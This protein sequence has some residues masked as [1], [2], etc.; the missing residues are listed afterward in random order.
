MKGYYLYSMDAEEAYVCVVTDRTIRPLREYDEQMC[1]DVAISYAY[2]D[3]KTLAMP[4]RDEL[5]ARGVSA[6]LL[7]VDTDPAEPLW[8][9][10]FREAAYHS[11]YFLPILTESYLAR[12]GTAVEL[13]DFARATVEHRG[14]EFFYPLIPVVR[15]LRDLGSNVFAKRGKI[16]ADYDEQLFEWIRT[17][18]FAVSST[19]GIDWL[20]RFF[21]SL[22][23]N[24]RNRFDPGFLHCLA[25]RIDFVE[26]RTVR[27]RPMVQFLIKSPVLTYHH[28]WMYDTGIVKYIG[29]GEPQPV[30]APR[31]DLGDVA[32]EILRWL[33]LDGSAETAGAPR[34]E[35]EEAPAAAPE[36]EAAILPERLFCPN[37]QAL[38]KPDWKPIRGYEEMRRFGGKSRYGPVMPMCP[39]CGSSTLVERSG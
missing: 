37:C 12:Q 19:E 24:S 15:D 4:L 11:Y 39:S 16:A 36:P 30:A 29:M 6:Y 17:H 7:D 21:S 1:F 38:R 13:F 27:G 34:P 14:T 18:I 9:I 3:R 5:A 31:S 32:G 2:E 28:F 35:P 23:S 8:G 22:A 25:P 10:R 20:A 26:L 33:K